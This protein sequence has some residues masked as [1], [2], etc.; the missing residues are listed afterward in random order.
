M[1][2]KEMRDKLLAADMDKYDQEEEE[3]EPHYFDTY[4]EEP[5]FDTSQEPFVPVTENN[6]YKGD[7]KLQYGNDNIPL[8]DSIPAFTRTGKQAY[9]N[10]N[11]HEDFVPDESP[12]E[13]LSFPEGRDRGK[14]QGRILRQSKQIKKPLD[15]LVH[16]DTTKWN[17]KSAIK[18]L[19]TLGCTGVAFLSNEIN[20]MHEPRVPQPCSLNPYVEPLTTNKTL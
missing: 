2:S 18:S 3:P 9:N 4:K 8:D 10:V 5:F 7:S 11:Y 19:F 12:Q 17:T 15:Q 6:A 13:I 1:P 16:N 20:T 14:G